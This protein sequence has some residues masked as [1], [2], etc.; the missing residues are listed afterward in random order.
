[1]DF[2]FCAK[3]ACN[4]EPGVAYLKFITAVSIVFMGKLPLSDITCNNWSVQFVDAY[5]AK[6]TILP[7]NATNGRKLNVQKNPQ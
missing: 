4:S 7:S 2:K 1:M 6:R 5:R 3:L